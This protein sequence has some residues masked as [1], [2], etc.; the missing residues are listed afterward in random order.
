MPN[1]LP[2]RLR[3]LCAAL[4]TAAT[5][6]PAVADDSAYGIAIH[7]GAGTLLREDMT[8]EKETVYRAKLAEATE[9]G[10]AVLEDNGSAMDAV[11]AAI[12]ILEDSPL[13]NAGIGAVFTYDGHHELDASIMDGATREAGAVAAVKHV[14]NPIDLARRVME[15]SP[16]VML[17]GDGAEAFAAT[18]DIPRVDNSLFS[19]PERREALDTWK[20]SQASADFSKP[21]DAD[22]K[23]GTVG[24]VAR[25]RAGNLAAG[26]STGGMTA[27][28]YGR[29]GD[30][31]IIGAGTWADNDSCA[32]SATG[33]GEY[34]IRYHVAAD[35]CSRVS[36]Q[37][38]DA[39]AAADAVIH[40]VLV[41]AGGAGG[42]IVMD[43]HGEVSMSFN[44][45]G[46]YRASRTS[47]RP[48]STAIFALER[49][50]KK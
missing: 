21:F 30:S 50:E 44:T 35:I 39:G 33:H 27:K 48:L 16:H 12:R 26:T 15:A 29:V 25:D 34:F 2:A 31:P 22:H 41:P 1:P 47:R 8:P 40:D 49:P 43:R 38:V 9:A 10:Y 14:R 13:F 24:A 19:T 36:Y 32:V 42:V 20:A 11:V 23:F 46:M 18:Q 28:R 3:R 37:G 45:E 4:F 7:G 17:V 5:V 6:A